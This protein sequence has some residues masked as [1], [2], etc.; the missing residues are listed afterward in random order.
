[1]TKIDNVIQIITPI[2][3]KSPVKRV[4]L[5]G[6]YAKELNTPDSDIDLIIDSNGELK[7][8]DFFALSAE[9]ARAL[10]MKS[11]I[12]EYREIKPNSAM[13]NEIVKDGVVIYG[14]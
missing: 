13:F 12:F 5:F 14:G 1:M 4:I 6:S 8:I 7:G 2:L 11:D 10:P 9:I 3:I